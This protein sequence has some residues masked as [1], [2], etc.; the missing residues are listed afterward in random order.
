MLGSRLTGPLSSSYS[1]LSRKA[2]CPAPGYL[3]TRGKLPTPPA[4]G[5]E[6]DEVGPLV[7]MEANLGCSPFNGQR[8][9]LARCAGNS[10]L[11]LRVL[12]R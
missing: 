2:R 9:E 7:P 8:G 12:F 5:R 10:E 4:G 1:D 3:K 6:H 11:D